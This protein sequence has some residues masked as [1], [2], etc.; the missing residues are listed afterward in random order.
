MEK[1]VLTTGALKHAGCGRWDID[2]RRVFGLAGAQILPTGRR[3]FVHASPPRGVRWRLAAS[4][5]AAIRDRLNRSHGDVELDAPARAASS[6]VQTKVL[7]PRKIVRAG[8]LF[9]CDNI[10]VGAA[11]S[12]KA[13]QPH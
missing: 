4:R 5:L 12:A 6:A 1:L 11:L 2:H 10:L 3:M 7:P 9:Q 13:Y 8:L